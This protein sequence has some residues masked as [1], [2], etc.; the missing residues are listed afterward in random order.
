MDNAALKRCHKCGELKPAT[1]EYFHRDRTA[2]DGLVSEC[3]VCARL[4]VKQWAADHPDR[5]REKHRRW[6][7]AHPGATVARAKKW[8]EEHP[9]QYKEVYD[10][11]RAANA[12]RIAAKRREYYEAH[13]PELYESHLRYNAAHPDKTHEITRRAAERYRQ[14]HPERIGKWARENSEKARL[15]TIKARARRR[16]LPNTLSEAD[17]QRALTHFGHA[18]AYCGGRGRPGETLQKDRV[19]PTMQG[20]GLTADNV[21]PACKSCNSSKQY[22]DLLD[23]YP[24][25]PLFDEFR[26]ARIQE[27]IAMAQ[28][29]LTAVGGVA[30]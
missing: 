5:V 23:W 6:D 2:K 25:Q 26:L 18:C 24:R 3:K 10:A 7:E 15:C 22:R 11:W 16:G 30:Q 13:Y 20:G 1:P 27:F 4:K 21:V 19:V 12:D 28:A 17:W 9:E 14:N 29:A 8:R